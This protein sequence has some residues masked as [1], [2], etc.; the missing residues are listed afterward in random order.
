MA[1][2]LNVAP[3]VGAWI[4]MLPYRHHQNCFASLPLWERGLKFDYAKEWLRVKKVAPLVGAWI[5]ILAKYPMRKLLSVAPLV[6]AWIEIEVY[7]LTWDCIESLPLWE[8]GL[9]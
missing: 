2:W 7:G 1:S 3:L 4:E 6:G 9:K 5:E 8:R